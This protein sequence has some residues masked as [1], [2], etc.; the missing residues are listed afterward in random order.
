MLRNQKQ[1]PKRSFMSKRRP[2]APHSSVPCWQ[3][4]FW[5]TDGSVCVTCGHKSH[6]FFRGIAK[7]KRPQ[8]TQMTVRH[9]QT[10]KLAPLPKNILSSFTRN[11]KFHRHKDCFFSAKLHD[12]IGSTSTV[13]QCARS[14]W[15]LY[16]T[17]C[18]VKRGKLRNTVER[19]K[20]ERGMRECSIL[21]VQL[22][23]F[24]CV[25]HVVLHGNRIL[26]A[27]LNGVCLTK[28][29]TISVYSITRFLRNCYSNILRS[30]DKQNKF[31]SF[32]NDHFLWQINIIE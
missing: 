31:K 9:L 15:H 27:V 14:P 2:A 29:Y 22:K 26:T 21:V 23:I 20:G 16:P 30:I 11:S 8:F 6:P 19:N 17:T 12:H 32:L 25:P 10:V 3:N 13:D 18:A 28:N 1:K 5:D 7:R 4:R 24:L